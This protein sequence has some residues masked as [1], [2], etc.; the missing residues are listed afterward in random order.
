MAYMIVIPKIWK[1]IKDS[2]NLNVTMGWSN[3]MPMRCNG[4]VYK[5]TAMH[6]IF[7]AWSR[8]DDVACVPDAIWVS[9]CPI[10]IVSYRLRTNEV[11]GKAFLDK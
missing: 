9:C 1:E 7:R 11:I 10:P 6:A 4:T 3:F 5:S 8:Y 2:N